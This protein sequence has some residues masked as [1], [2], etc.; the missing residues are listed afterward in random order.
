M[1]D[2]VSQLADDQPTT[3]LQRVLNLV[4]RALSSRPHIIFLA[5]L[6]VYLVLLP[7]AHV[8]V[9]AFAELVGGN[10]TNVTSDLGACIA[11]GGTIHI[12]RSHRQHR[13]ELAELR[14]LVEDLSRTLGSGSE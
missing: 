2:S 8:H 11:A 1:T 13:S 12:M 10:Y 3:R 14:R 4:P 7:L 6:G 9:S 5:V